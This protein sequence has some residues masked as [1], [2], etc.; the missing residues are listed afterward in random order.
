MHRAGAYALVSAELNRWATLPRQEVAARVGAPATVTTA[1]L[2][3]E[4]VSIEVRVRWGDGRRTRLRV[5]A[6]AYGPSHWNTERL[7]DAIT[8]EVDPLG[9]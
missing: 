1:L 7:D 3:G 4:L 5:E 6:V 9:A 8:L 2:D